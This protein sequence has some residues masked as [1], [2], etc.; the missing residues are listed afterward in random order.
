MEDGDINKYDL[1]RLQAELEQERE[2]KWV[3][4]ID[5]INNT[6]QLKL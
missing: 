6:Q 3:W 5:M 1:V 2:I 4:L